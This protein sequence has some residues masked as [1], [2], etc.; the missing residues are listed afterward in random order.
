[1]ARQNLDFG[2]GEPVPM[3]ASP[4]RI[5]ACALLMALLA[6]VHPQTASA[7]VAPRITID[8]N[9]PGAT[10]FVDGALQSERTG[11]AT[12]VRINKGQHKLRL[13]LEGYR[14]FEQTVTIG[15][16][17]GRQFE[18]PLEQNMTVQR[19]TAAGGMAVVLMC[20]GDAR[21]LAAHRGEC[22]HAME[23]LR[24]TGELVSDGHR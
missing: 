8:S 17:E 18:V 13:E 7:Q 23:S 21:V 19:V 16:L 15:D 11:P 2:A 3:L 22:Q 1:M 12:K 4:I 9:P 14:P 6:I 20:S 24:M 10:I 5:T